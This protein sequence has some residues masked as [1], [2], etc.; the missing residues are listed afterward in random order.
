MDLQAVAEALAAQAATVTCSPAL[1]TFAYAPDSIP[2]P[3]AFVAEMEIEFD[4]A[5]RR[6]LDEVMVTMR[7]LVGRADD[8]AAAA[9]LNG[10]MSGSGTGSLKT[11]LEADRI[12]N[13]GDALGGACHD[14]HVTRIQGHR[15]YEHAST[16]YL[17]GEWR[18]RV[19]GPG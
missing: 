15:W 11:A 10:L 16:T 18:I 7:V 3:C 1:N 2:E 17:G 8:K 13:G 14:Y 19:I 4:K 12:P 6:A 5:M 9:R